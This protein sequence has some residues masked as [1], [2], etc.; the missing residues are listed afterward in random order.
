M[1][2]ACRQ[3]GMG[4]MGA[5]LSGPDEIAA[6]ADAFR[7]ESSGSFQLNTWI[8]DPPPPRDP[9]AEERLRRFLAGWG[10]EVPPDAAD[11]RPKDFDSQCAAFLATKP[12]AVSSI[13]GVFPSPFVQNLKISG[14]AWFAT[15]Q[16]SH[17]V[18]RL[19]AIAAPLIRTRPNGNAWGFFLSYRWF[20]TGFQFRLLRLAVDGRGLA[21]PPQRSGLAFSGPRKRI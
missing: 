15:A 4:A 9:E 12:R 10:P 20:Q 18:L 7:R 13:M 1:A 2:G 5:S 17:K 21:P 6:W 14:I 8:P 16:S 11:L 3:R 19:A